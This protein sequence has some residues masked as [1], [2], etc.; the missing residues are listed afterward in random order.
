MKALE[1]EARLDPEGNLRVPADL[2]AQ[3][4]KEKSVRVIVLVRERPEEEDWRRLTQDGFLRGYSQS[5]GI[6]DAV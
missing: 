3:I 1:F 2:A 5:N 4:P 6:Y